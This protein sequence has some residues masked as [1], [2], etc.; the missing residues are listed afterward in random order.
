MT[1]LQLPHLH[2]T[3]VNKFLSTN[4]SNL[5]KFELVSSHARVTSMKST[6]Q[7]SVSE[8]VSEFSD[9][10]ALDRILNTAQL[11]WISAS[12]LDSIHPLT[13]FIWS[14]IVLEKASVKKKTATKYELSSSS[15]LGASRPILDPSWTLSDHF[16]PAHIIY[17]CCF[18]CLRSFEDLHCKIE[19]STF[20]G[21]ETR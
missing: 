4:I 12:K 2:Q 9:N 19:F 11:Q 1:K 18:G 3:F 10:D 7:Q 17:H 8:S 5:N 21:F 16:T 20:L 14:R 15:R 6:K 13:H